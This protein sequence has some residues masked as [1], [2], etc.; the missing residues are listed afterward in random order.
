[1][2]IDLLLFTLHTGPLAPAALVLVLLENNEDAAEVVHV[3][4]HYTRQKRK[5]ASPLVAVCQK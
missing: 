4:K 3:S 1:M 5:N 2:K